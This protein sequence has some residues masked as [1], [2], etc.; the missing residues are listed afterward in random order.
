MGTSACLL[1][2]K[3]DLFLELLK[4]LLIHNTDVLFRNIFKHEGNHILPI[5]EVIDFH[6]GRNFMN[7]SFR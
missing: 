7:G 1:A 3:R 6:S 2:L 4:M 5:F